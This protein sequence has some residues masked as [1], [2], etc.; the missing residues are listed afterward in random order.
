MG[1]HIQFWAYSPHPPSTNHPPGSR[2]P[3]IGLNQ[4]RC[5]DGVM[6]V[7]IQEDNS[8]T[9]LPF[10]GS[11]CLSLSQLGEGGIMELVFTRSYKLQF[12]LRRRNV[13]AT[14]YLQEHVASSHSTDTTQISRCPALAGKLV[15]SSSKTLARVLVSSLPQRKATL[16]TIIHST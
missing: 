3:P 16:S 1:I 11:Q 9:L 6:S 15:T 5:D 2:E 4:P 10:H 7:V 12:T 14:F 8:P 13:A